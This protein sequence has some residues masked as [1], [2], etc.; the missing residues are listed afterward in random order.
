MHEEYI[1]ANIEAHPDLARCCPP[2][3]YIA[4]STKCY[5][6]KHQPPFATFYYRANEYEI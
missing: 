4:V 1:L 6:Q 3:R 2:L 5:V